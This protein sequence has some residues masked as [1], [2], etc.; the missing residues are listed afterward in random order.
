MQLQ[1]DDSRITL[2]LFLRLG[3]ERPN[4]WIFSHRFVIYQIKPVQHLKSQHSSLITTIPL[5][6]EF[7]IRSNLSAPTCTCLLGLAKN[8]SLSLLLSHTHQG[9]HFQYH[10][11]QPIKLHPSELTITSHATMPDSSQMRFIKFPLSN[12]T[13]CHIVLYQ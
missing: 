8:L 12:A 3:G 5:L 9:P 1:I 10:L 13:L 6:P 4:T 2:I 11:G 7:V